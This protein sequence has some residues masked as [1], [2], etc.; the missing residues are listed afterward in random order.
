MFNIDVDHESKRRIVVIQW[1]KQFPGLVHL[2]SKLYFYTYIPSMRLTRLFKPLCIALI[3][4]P[5][6]QREVDPGFLRPANPNDSH[7]SIYLKQYTKLDTT[8]PSGSDTLL[9]SMISY[10]AQK[11]VIMISEYDFIFNELTVIN[12]FYSGSDTL[13]YKTVMNYGDFIS[14][15]RDTSFFTYTN[16]IVSRDSTIT[17]DITNNTFFDTRVKIF[18]PSGNNTFIQSRGYFG[19]PPITPAYQWN[20]AMLQTRVNGNLTRQ[21][22]T[23]TYN[24]KH[25]I[26]DHYEADYDNKINP[27]YRVTIHYPINDFDTQKNN[28]TEEKAWDGPG[29]FQIHTKYNYIYRNDGYPLSVTE[30]DVINGD[31]LKSV[32]TYTN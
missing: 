30:T 14:D 5:A 11:R 19:Y 8:L 1:N 13:P 24:V 6:C 23:S 26:R 7:D 22:D 15:Y 18:T 21:D 27:L 10:D 29:V 9:R 31:K 25:S 32:F 17:F 4:L 12:Y 16:G 20:G 28:I 2:K 3:I